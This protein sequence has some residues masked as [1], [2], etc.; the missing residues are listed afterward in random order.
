M[1]VQGTTP[2]NVIHRL[3]ITPATTQRLSNNIYST[4][5]GLNSGVIIMFGP[6]QRPKTRERAGPGKILK[7]HTSPY[8]PHSIYSANP[9]TGKS[10]SEGTIYTQVRHLVTDSH[11]QQIPS[12]CDSRI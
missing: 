4:Q 3:I 1:P 8:L 9:S 7:R 2:Q 5:V 6:L 10:S 12:R 11:S